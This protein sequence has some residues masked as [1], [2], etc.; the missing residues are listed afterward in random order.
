MTLATTKP[1]LSA[2]KAKLAKGA[3]KEAWALLEALPAS[4]RVGQTAAMTEA[5]L[6][7]RLGH[8][9]QAQQVLRNH[10]AAHPVGRRTGPPPDK[11]PTALV[12]RGFD[13]S[14]ATLG[15]SKDGSY[16]V[17]LRGG[18]F[19][20]K[21]LLDATT[22]GKQR[23]TIAGGSEVDATALPAHH[24]MLNTIS[25]VDLERRSLE[26]LDRY[27]QAH[28]Q[29]NVINHPEKVLRT[30]RDGN[31]DRLQGIEGVVFPR[32]RKLRFF[33][34]TPAKV[35]AQLEA[36]GFAFPF[37][38]RQ[39][40]TQ[41]GRSTALI[42]SAEALASY[43]GPSGLMG[44]YYAIAYRDIRWNG[45]DFYRKLRL[46]CIDGAFFPV[47]CHLDKV[48]NVHGGNRRTIMAVDPT[49]TDEEKRFLQDWRSYCGPRAVAGLEQAA[50]DTG[51]EFF[52]IDFTIDDDGR[53]FIYELN[54]SMRHSFDH[55]RNF[56]YKLPY[57]QATS[58]AFTKMVLRRAASA[59]IPQER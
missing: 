12:M 57:D 43:V 28:P 20:L 27:L 38:L 59:L 8:G 35:M 40:G 13:Q 21:Y 39:T 14:Y 51:L 48:W 55:A 16:K 36:A 31:F 23:Y 34:E 33:G 41:T 11:R 49:L 2:V 58:A 19:T 56:P 52:G 5:A 7:R 50:E 26:A 42:D 3:F 29:T 37:I 15:K 10:F 9:V 30:S 1:D 6:G 22:I 24:V 45:T 18:H 53:A 25:D 47:V 32:T 46:F 54:A 4:A 17:K 44:P